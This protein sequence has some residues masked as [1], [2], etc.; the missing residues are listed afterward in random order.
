MLQLQQ[1][2]SSSTVHLDKLF[3]ADLLARLAASVATGQ[4]C[5]ISIISIQLYCTF[6]DAGRT[7][8]ALISCR[9]SIQLRPQLCS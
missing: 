4:K 1:K 2:T 5:Y 7:T 6:L 9:K 8:R 3:H